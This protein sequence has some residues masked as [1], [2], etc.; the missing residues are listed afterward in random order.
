MKKNLT[1]FFAMLLTAVTVFGVAA[2]ERPRSVAPTAAAGMPQLLGS[3]IWSATESD[4]F[5]AY[6]LFTIPTNDSQQFNRLFRYANA[7]YGGVLI[8]KTYYTCEYYEF[9]GYGANI[10]YT[11]YDLETGREVYSASGTAYTYSM[12]YDATTSTV[13]AIANLDRRFV[14]VKIIFDT[15]NRRMILD[16]VNVITLEEYGL[17][18]SI[19][20]DSKG[21]LWGIYSDCVL[22][23]SDD[24]PMVCTGS[25][26]YKINKETAALTKVGET[27]FDSLYA[28]DATFDLKTD[29]LFWT[30]SNASD[31][32]LLTEVD[33]TT[34]K[35]TVIYVFPGNEEVTGLVIPTP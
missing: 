32:G 11:G 20:C 3:V 2:G 14:L 21:Q 22:P 19:A 23:Q 29:R 31:E 4:Y 12:T 13:Y 34:G 25:T 17:W 16:P 6:G 24:D 7:H 5:S 27:G 15:E 1:R 26:L 10:Y 8:D 9:P 18:N 35:A 30:V 33:T 28:S